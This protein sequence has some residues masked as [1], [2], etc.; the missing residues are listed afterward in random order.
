MLAKTTI[1]ENDKDD[2]RNK[3]FLF[4]RLHITLQ[5]YKIMDLL[6]EKKFLNSWFFIV[7]EK[8]QGSRST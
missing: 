7:C 5:R 6:H 8:V 4:V 1:K 2:D 3:M